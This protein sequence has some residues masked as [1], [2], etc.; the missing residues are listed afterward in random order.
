MSRFGQQLPAIIPQPRAAPNFSDAIAGEQLSR[1]IAA[2]AQTTNASLN[3]AT[4]VTQDKAQI[5]AGEQRLTIGEMEI[6]EAKTRAGTAQLR[7]EQFQT[8]FDTEK[9][10]KKAQELSELELFGAM[11]VLSEMGPHEAAK[12]PF[13]DPKNAAIANRVIGGQLASIGNQRIYQQISEASLPGGKGIRNLDWMGMVSQEIARISSQGFVPPEALV[14]VRES[15]LST[16]SGAMREFISRDI[17]QKQ[18]FYEEE[19]RSQARFALAQQ[20]VGDVD[21]DAAIST[22]KSRY[23]IIPGATDDGAAFARVAADDIFAMVRDHP[24]T[25]SDP[26]QMKSWLESFLSG[27][28][29]RGVRENVK[30]LGVLSDLDTRITKEQNTKI[31]NYVSD[32]HDRIE[33]YDRINSVPGLQS[34]LNNLDETLLPPDVL[35]KERLNIETRIQRA[36][37]MNTETA[38]LMSVLSGQMNRE[39]APQRFS[40]KALDHTWQ[41]VAS[42]VGQET[43]AGTF[44]QKLGQLPPD[45]V[46]DINDAFSLRSLDMDRGLGMLNAIDAANPNTSSLII[47]TLDNADIAKLA[48][49]VT[50]GVAPDSRRYREIVATL[51]DPVALSSIFTIDP[52]DENKAPKLAIAMNESS[53]MGEIAER[54]DMDRKQIPR[55]AVRKYLDHFKLRYMETVTTPMF[56]AASQDAILGRAKELALTDIERRFTVVDVPGEGDQII[57]LVAMGL[58][59][60]FAADKKNVRALERGLNA[61]RMKNTTMRMDQSVRNGDAILIPLVDEDSDLASIEEAV[62]GFAQWN[63]QDGTIKRISSGPD[64]EHGIQQLSGSATIEDVNPFAAIRNTGPPMSVSDFDIQYPEGDPAR[65]GPRIVQL[66]IRKWKSTYGALPSRDDPAFDSFM[67][68]MEE[69]AQQSGYTGFGVSNRTEEETP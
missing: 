22:L 34:E 42:V 67:Q 40:D 56:A 13:A 30:A 18:S 53:A 15:M 11:K 44:M 21:R 6:E 24:D 54:L 46:H 12:Y 55:P 68:M 50:R 10:K 31:N 64:Y 57:D 35:K 20:Y 63:P 52:T 3:F 14:E 8:L 1:I 5:K 2:A 43:A 65:V 48:Y 4:N 62:K 27:D 23:K 7:L 51:K 28:E 58:P 32:L 41:E 19:A 47:A 39:D 29:M 69:I 66:A 9:E 36:Q 38:S 60:T 59:A 61:A 37:Q 33:S 16:A 49:N 17:K 26:E 45:A 25:D